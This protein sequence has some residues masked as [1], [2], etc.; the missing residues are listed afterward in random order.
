MLF[1]PSVL[2]KE[3]LNVFAIAYRFHYEA[4]ARTA[5]TCLWRQPTPPAK[6]TTLEYISQGDLRNLSVYRNKCTYAVLAIGNNLTWF[7]QKESYGFPKW[8]TNPVYARNGQTHGS[9]GWSIWRKPWLFHR[10]LLAPLPYIKMY[11]KQWRGLEV[12]RSVGES[13]S[14]LCRTLCEGL[15]RQLIRKWRA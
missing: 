5:A 12:A 13:R 2:E 9:G 1:E 15:R 11:G 7:R 14:P 3:P 4:E 8:W 10:K 6:S